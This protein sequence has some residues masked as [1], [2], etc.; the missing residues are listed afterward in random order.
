V[1]Q[2][3]FD[4][5]DID[6]GPAEARLQHP[7]DLEYVE[8]TLFVADTYNNKIKS[9]GLHT[10]NVRTFCGDGHAGL[11]DGPSEET[12]F[13]EPAHV[14]RVVDIETG[15]AGTFD[16]QDAHKLARRRPGIVRLGPVP[17]RPG[18]VTLQITCGLPKGAM[19]NS[20]APSHLE[21]VQGA[22]LQI[23]AVETDT[24]FAK[25][26]SDAPARIETSVFFCDEEKQGV[27]LYSMQT[28][29]LT[30]EEDP[31]AQSHLCVGLSTAS[32]RW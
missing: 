18:E 26:R 2:G 15:E 30:F 20:G 22:D 11:V 6:G 31:G 3:L 27:C 1:G 9:I 10:R 24:V 21:I 8:G 32:S 5:G 7:L 17:V 14:I 25:V 4:F 12:R 29:E 19:L 13:D 28:Y 16:L 23:V